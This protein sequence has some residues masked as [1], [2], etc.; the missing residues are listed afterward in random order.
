MKKLIL[1]FTVLAMVFVG[2]KKEETKPTNSS[3]GNSN[4]RI[5]SEIEYYFDQSGKVSDSTVT[6]ASYDANGRIIS[7]I[8]KYNNNSIYSSSI[9]Y[10]SLSMMTVNLSYKG[11]DT[12]YTNKLL[13]FL[14]SKGLIT[15]YCTEGKKDTINFYYSPDGFLKNNN[16]DEVVEVVNGNVVK[17]GNTTYE[18][19][20]DKTNTIGNA[21][22]G[23][24]FLGNESKN[25]VKSEKYTEPNQN[26]DNYTH[27]YAYVYEFDSKNRVI[28]STKTSTSNGVSNTKSK[29]I[30]KYTYNN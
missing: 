12:S 13:Y 21:Y 6:T 2:C 3:A 16:I 14:D 7:Q 17:Q 29:T 23:I 15:K 22:R 5:L 30:T 24:N 28:K 9:V 10:S 25:L 19:Y 4:T 11:S 18:Y 26:G 8:S 1:S 27:E 20:L